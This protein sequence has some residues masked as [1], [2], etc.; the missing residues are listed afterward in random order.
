M[1]GARVKKRQ[2]E[3]KRGQ[4]L[5]D[6]ELFSPCTPAEPVGSYTMLGCFSA[7]LVEIIYIY[8]YNLTIFLCIL[9]F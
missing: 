1:W 5:S 6:S 8:M 2:V 9:C 4:E 7:V 3:S